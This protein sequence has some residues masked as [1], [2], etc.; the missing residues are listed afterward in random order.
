MYAYVDST[1]TLYVDPLGLD[2]SEKCSGTLGDLMRDGLH[3]L[4]PRLPDYVTLSFYTVIRLPRGYVLPIGAGLTLDRAGNV[5]FTP[6]TGYRGYSF[7]AG[8]LIRRDFNATAVNNL[9]EGPSFTGAVGR[10][11]GGNVTQSLTSACQAV[12]FGIVSSPG[13]STGIGF[14][15]GNVLNYFSPRN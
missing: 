5:Y 9:L 1:P 15:L 12:E 6:G 10:Y 8:W 14:K 4:G 11:L 7:T 3:A 13:A 2:R